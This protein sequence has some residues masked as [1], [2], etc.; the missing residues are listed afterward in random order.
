MYD[1]LT[2]I[3]TRRRRLRR[4]TYLGYTVSRVLEVR[5]ILM[6]SKSEEY[7]CE[8]LYFM[9][10]IY[11]TL[12]S[13]FYI[14]C[15]WMSTLHDLYLWCLWVYVLFIF[16]MPYFFRYLCKCLHFDALRFR[17][18]CFSRVFIMVSFICTLILCFIYFPQFEPFMILFFA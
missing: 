5:V 10:C 8:Y 3:K 6:A 14:L 1:H 17:M 16:N 7:I 12:K 2:R 15:V 9:V 13:F 11:Y 18:N 4:F